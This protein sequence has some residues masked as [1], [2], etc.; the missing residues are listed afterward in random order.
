MNAH[1]TIPIKE[2]DE[3]IKYC[4]RK[5]NMTYK[6]VVAILAVIGADT[7]QF[8]NYLR[9]SNGDLPDNKKADQS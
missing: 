1:K 4:M 3:D 6:R 9:E 8:V 2:L 7:H 5:Y